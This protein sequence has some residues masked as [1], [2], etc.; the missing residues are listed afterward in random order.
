MIVFKASSSLPLE[1]LARGPIG[2]RND[3]S[4]SMYVHFIGISCAVLM[5][6]ARPT[7]HT[8]R[9]STCKSHIFH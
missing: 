8:R 5:L 7:A 6:V 4:F 3:A 9:L 2:L 1:D